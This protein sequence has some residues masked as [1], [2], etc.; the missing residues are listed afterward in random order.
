MEN[1]IIKD[2]FFFVRHAYHL[3]SQ[4]K[5]SVCVQ[6]RNPRV[7]KGIIEALLQ[8]KN[9][10]QVLIFFFCSLCTAYYVRCTCIVIYVDL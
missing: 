10:S 3:L 6:F 7:L 1:F 2:L 4:R 5:K 8:K 9:H